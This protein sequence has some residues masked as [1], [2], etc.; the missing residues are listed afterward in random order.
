MAKQQ[1]S[2]VYDKQ[3]PACNYYCQLIR[4]NETVGELILIDARDN[5]PIMEKITSQGLDIDQGMVLVIDGTLYY[6]ADAIQ[7]LALMSSRSGFFNQLNYQ[8]F[9]HPLIAKN[10]YPLL[11]MSRNILLKLLRKTKINNLNLK[12]NQHF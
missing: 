6:G 3:C 12:N 1:L 9:K 11:R 2:L 7:A 4:I 5:D 8:I 10:L